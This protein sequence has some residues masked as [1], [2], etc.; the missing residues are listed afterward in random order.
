MKEFTKTLEYKDKTFNL[1]FN[2]NVMESIQ[3]EYGSLE[4]WGELT[5]GTENGEPNAKAVIFGFKEMINEGID[6]ENEENGTSNP[7]LT[8]KQVGRIVTEVGLNNA[9]QVLNETVVESTKSEEKNA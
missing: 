2:L 9:T 3:D 1:V 5:D 4:H 6:I 8:L 7:F